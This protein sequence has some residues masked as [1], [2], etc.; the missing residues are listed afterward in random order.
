MVNVFTGLIFEVSLLLLFLPPELGLGLALPGGESRSAA[1][2]ALFVRTEDVNEKE[3]MGVA[4][5]IRT[6]TTVK[7]RRRSPPICL[8]MLLEALLF[9]M[10]N[11]VS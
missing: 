11:K 1:T 4:E 8:L 6:S 5:S 9:A 2:V 3:Q 10:M 7:L